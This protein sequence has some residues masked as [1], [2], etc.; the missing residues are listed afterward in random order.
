MDYR[1]AGVDIEEGDA[2]VQIVKRSIERRGRALPSAGAIGGFSG[3]FPIGGGRSLAACCDGVGTKLAIGEATGMFRGLGQDLVAMSVNDLATCGAS[4]LFF[5]DYIACG[6][7]DVRKM[8]SVLEGIL[9]ACEE[10]GC[11][12][13]GGETAEMPG[14]YPPGGFD[15]AGFAVGLAD[16]GKI[17]DGSGINEGDVIIALPSSGVHSNGFSLVRRALLDDGLKLPLGSKPEPL[18]GATLAETLMKPTRLYVRQARAAMDSTEVK[19]KGMA[20]I[21]GGG[22]EANINRVIPDGLVSRIDYESWERPAIFRL[23]ESA[24]VEE[25]EMRKVFNLGAGYVFIVSRDDE[26]RLFD[27]LE[28]VGESPMAIGTVV[29][30]RASK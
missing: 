22:L 24:G 1:S 18:G 30:A 13:L 28:A 8:E 4:P 20:N 14:I 6:R 16:D 26:R 3:L 17:V 27:A 15:L 11:A 5:L 25:A 19:V 9:D 10:S 29:R 7:L 2:W 21:T 12:L 23:I